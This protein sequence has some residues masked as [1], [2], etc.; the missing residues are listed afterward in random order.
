[1]SVG[2]NSA[3]SS[4]IVSKSILLTRS[5]LCSQLAVWQARAAR[6]LL[7]GRLQCKPC[8][9]L[10]LAPEHVCI[11]SVKRPQRSARLVRGRRAG[12]FYDIV[13]PSRG[14]EVNKAVATNGIL[15]GALFWLFQSYSDGA[16]MTNGY[17]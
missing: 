5:N 7:Q 13:L 15:Q 17:G 2:Y 16:N 11:T 9:H 6:R 12:A 1:M 14:Q 4:Q 3:S 8:L 10:G